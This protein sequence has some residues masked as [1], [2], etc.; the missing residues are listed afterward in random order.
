MST[1]CFSCEQTL[2]SAFSRISVL[3]LFHFTCCAII[4]VFLKKTA[5]MLMLIRFHLVHRFSQCYQI[6]NFYAKSPI[7]HKSERTC[8]TG[9]HTVVKSCLVL[10]RLWSVLLKHVMKLWLPNRC[11]QRTQSWSGGFS[12]RSQTCDQKQ[13][14]RRTLKGPR[15]EK[16]IQMHV[17][18][19]PN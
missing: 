15:T 9:K 10:K 18:G 14:E 6:S 11:K 4:W 16:G 13:M 3:C 1:C 8:T 17:T 12:L 19:H 7:I 2:H 5:V